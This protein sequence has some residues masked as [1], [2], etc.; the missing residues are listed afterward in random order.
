MEDLKT[1][2]LEFIAD[3]RD[4]VFTNAD[5][6]GDLAMVEFFFK[7]QDKTRTFNHFVQHVLPWKAYVTNRDSSFF[8][9]NREI[10]QGLPE[11]R[12]DHFSSAWTDPD[13]ISD[14]DKDIIWSYFDTL[15]AIVERERK[16]K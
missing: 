5:D 12:I 4:S 3:L 15:I 9:K 16:R 10:F 11:D 1:T 8:V 6:L 7:Q 14:E 13:R 2:V